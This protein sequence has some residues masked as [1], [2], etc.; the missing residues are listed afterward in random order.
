MR[1]V[2]IFALA[3]V[4]F[5]LIAA[6]G[7]NKLQGTWEDSD[8]YLWVFSR[9][10]VQFVKYTR[11]G[12]IYSST[13]GKYTITDNEISILYDE[14]N[15]VR[16]FEILFFGDE[17]SIKYGSGSSSLRLI[18]IS[19]SQ[20]PPSVF[21]PNREFDDGSDNIAPAPAPGRN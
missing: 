7:G 20:T 10:R 14:N 5:L 18:R 3:V 15:N 12:E 9:D 6:C 21:I 16:T 1:K 8:G 4:A 19:S 17:M 13:K 11:D 2:Y